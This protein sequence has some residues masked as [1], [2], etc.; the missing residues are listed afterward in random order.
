MVS[1]MKV[2]LSK[3]VRDAIKLDSSDEFL[4]SG[5]LPKSAMP[6]RLGGPPVGVTEYEFIEEHIKLR[7]RNEAMIKM[8]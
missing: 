6:E 5:E 8:Q 1:L 3:K 4:A 2:F 7:A